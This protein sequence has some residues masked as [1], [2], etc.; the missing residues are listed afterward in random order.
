MKYKKYIIILVILMAVLASIAAGVGIF[1]NTS[2]QAYFYQTIRGESIE[3]YGRGLY[4]HMSADVAIQGIAQ[5]Y[6]TLFIGVPVL[7]IALFFSVQGS[8]KAQLI[9]TGTSLYFLV[10][11]LFYTAMAMYNTL[12]LVYVMLLGLSFFTF[13]L[14][15]ISFEPKALFSHHKIYR[16]SGVFLMINAVMIGLLWLGVVVP[17][18][19][20]GSLYPAGLDHYT[21]LIV[22][23]FDLGLLL[24]LSFVVGVLAFKKHHY[25]YFFATVY[26]IFLSFLMTAL[27]SKIAFMASVGQNVI[28]VIFIMPSIALISMGLTY[29]NLKAIEK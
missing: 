26:V 15:L 29:Q 7:L 17:P 5:D 22:Q 3:I 28:P 9:L 2:G 12:F 20:D 19:L 27:T 6:V 23:G 18:L 1:Y 21:T 14:N 25:G 8:R 13:I 16:Y 11:Y 10:T 4:K 24:P